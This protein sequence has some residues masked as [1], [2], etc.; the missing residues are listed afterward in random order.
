MN[1]SDLQKMLQRNG[2]RPT[3]Q[4]QVSGQLQMCM[5]SMWTKLFQGESYKSGLGTLLREGDCAE[6]V[7][8]SAF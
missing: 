5:I 2:W 7:S 1:G 3:Q 6:S 4:T 8:R